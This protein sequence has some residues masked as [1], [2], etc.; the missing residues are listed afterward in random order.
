MVG[1]PEDIPIDTSEIPFEA[2]EGWEPPRQY[3][4]NTVDEVDEIKYKVHD[5][6]GEI[7]IARPERNNVLTSSMRYGIY[8]AVKRSEMDDDVKVILINAEG[9]NFSGGHD[10]SQVYKAYQVYDGKDAGKKQPSMRSRLHRDTQI[11]EAYKGILFSLK[12]II[13]QVQGWCI[14]GALALVFGSDIT[15]ASEDAKFSHR[16]QRLT[17]SGN[18]FIDALEFLELGPRKTRELMLTGEA[19]SGQEAEDVGFANHVVPN[20]ELEDEVNR[21]CEAINLL[22]LDGIVI[23]SEMANVAYKT[24]GMD[25]D[26]EMGKVGHTL[27]TQLRFEDGE[28]NFVRDRQEK[29][30]AEAIKGLHGRFDDLGF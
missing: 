14:G 17:F 24:L 10:L 6:I 4:R 15:I 1:N 20:D 23:G 27:S 2:L 22:P 26:I 28:Y 30:L 5:G 13:T 18:Q 12:P 9:K 25:M 29:G 7:T 16:E 21:Y 8:D 19:I 11:L 3:L